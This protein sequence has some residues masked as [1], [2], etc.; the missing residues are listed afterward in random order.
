M[1]QAFT[2]PLSQHLSQQLLHFAPQVSRRSLNV[3]PEKLKIIVINKLLNLVLVEQLKSD[4]LHFLQQKWVGI[5]VDDIGLRFEVSVDT[6]LRVRSFT[7]PDVTFSANVPELVLVAAGKEDPDTLFFQRKLRIEGDTELGLEVKN[8][9]LSI[10]LENLP[11]PA[12]IGIEKFAKMLQ[13]LTE[14]D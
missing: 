14:N 6:Q 13:I 11:K 10:E 9:L 2:Q 1:A 8:M 3:M 12:Q 7:Q 5:C 4:E